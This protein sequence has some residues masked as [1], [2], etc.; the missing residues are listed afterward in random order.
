[1]TTNQTAVQWLIIQLRKLSFNSETHIGFG[2][3]ILRREYLDNIEEKA[4]ELD[5]RHIKTKQQ[6][7]QRLD[8]S[9]KE[10][11]KIMEWRDEAYDKY[12]KSKK[13]WGEADIAEYEHTCKIIIELNAE[14]NAFKWVLASL[15]E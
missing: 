4:L 7:Q 14:I 15:E 2:D 12:V 5:K 11:R 1:M 13:I 10:K 9:I 8:Q 6:I 3:A